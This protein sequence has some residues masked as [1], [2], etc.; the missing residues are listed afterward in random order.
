MCREL[1]YLEA[2]NPGNME[3]SVYSSRVSRVVVACKQQERN[4]LGH[5]PVHYDNSFGP[6]FE[7]P[8]RNMLLTMSS[9]EV[10]TQ[11]YFTELGCWQHVWQST[12]PTQLSQHS[13]VNSL[14]TEWCSL[15]LRF[16]T[17]LPNY[18]DICLCSSGIWSLNG[19]SSISSSD[20][21]VVTV[22]SLVL[23]LSLWLRLCLN[24]CVFWKQE[25][26]L[27]HATVTWQCNIA[28][29]G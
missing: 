16:L 5:L 4:T 23:L 25:R 19:T 15:S 11:S 10:I 3:K 18:S 6:L 2:E 17:Q 26:L 9:G 24:I 14:L 21:R 8:E 20:C 12:L 13:L 7:L 29:S 22:L 1:C 28:L 27:S